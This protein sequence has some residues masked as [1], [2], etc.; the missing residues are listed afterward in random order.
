MVEIN[1]QNTSHDQLATSDFEKLLLKT[2]FS[3]PSLLSAAYHIF[4]REFF[5]F[6]RINITIS[7]MFA[8]LITALL[9]SWDSKIGKNTEVIFQNFK[10]L[11]NYGSQEFL[12]LVILLFTWIFFSFLRAAFLAT[13]SNYY[14][15]EK[16]LQPLHFGLQKT[17]SFLVVELMQIVM[18]AIGVIM[19]VFAPLFGA[20]Y[21]VALPAMINQD[22]DGISSMIESK[23][24]TRNKIF[25]V[26]FCM[27]YIT[28]FS[29]LAVGVSAFVTS[30]FIKD[31]LT[32]W[33]LNLT[34]FNSFIL[35]IHSAFR[36]TAYRKLQHGTGQLKYEVGFID[37]LWFTSLRL[38]FLAF[39]LFNIYLI[40]T[41]TLLEFYTRIFVMI[42]SFLLQFP[43][44]NKY[45]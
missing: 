23:E 43:Y 9:A 5:S 30:I 16:D 36:F 21:F 12:I 35:P 2:K 41:G 17:F 3:G 45:L 25:G 8:V 22:D 1:S 38:F 20:R 31:N 7:A 27:I 4:S 13:I 33:L 44:I 24:Y 42:H 6:L 18:L 19:I 40:S 39:L 10:L 26:I 14:S 37:K 32:F 28:L 11:Q 29:L 15:L 34:I